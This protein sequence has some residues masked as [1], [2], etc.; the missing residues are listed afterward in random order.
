MSDEWWGLEDPPPSAAWPRLASGR[1]PRA[2]GTYGPEVLAWASERRLHPKR[3][4]VRRWWQRAVAYRALEYDHAGDLCWGTVMVSGPRQTG[5]SWLERDVCAWR[6]HQAERWGEEQALLHVAHKLPAAQEVWRP[7]ARWA[8]GVYGP[9]TVRWANGE[10]QIELP[11]GS[12]WMIQAANDGSG[13]AFSLSHVLVDEAWR[14]PRVVF[15]DAIVP[16]MAESASPQAWLVSTAG[17]SDSDLMLG[18]R[19]AAIAM[20]GADDPGDLAILEWSAPPD[21]DVDIDDRR[22]WRAATPHWD[23]RRETRMASARSMTSER[24]FRQQWLNQWVPAEKPPLLGPDVW[25]RVVTLAAPSGRVSFGVDVEAD[26]AAAVILAMGGG[27][28]ELVER[29]P[30]ASAVARV[31]DLAANHRASAVGVDASGPA[32]SLV[33]PLANVL[34]VRLVAM[35]GAD[36]AAASGDLFDRMTANPRGVAFRAHP[37]LQAAVVSAR[38][39]SYGQRWAWERSPAPGVSGAPMVAASCAVWAFDHAPTPVGRFEIQ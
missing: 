39:R 3:S 27:V 10:Q 16:T 36:T 2:V 22:V 13:V 6:I 17:T 35:S 26:R 34:G 24:A 21:L 32:A 14:V 31:A 37:L 29:L 18:N 5:K 20:L 15:D 33:G 25:G 19:V 8:A 30:V 38:T 4:S 12:R 7:A 9:R 1:H 28:L 11:D 23:D